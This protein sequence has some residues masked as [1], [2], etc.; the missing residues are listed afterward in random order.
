MLR[1]LINREGRMKNLSLASLIFPLFF[2]SLCAG[3]T[4]HAKTLKDISYGDAKKQKLDVYLPDNTAN[5]PIMFMVHG[6]A[7]RIGDKQNHQVVK[8]KVE[9]WR[10]RGWVFISINY[11]MLPKADPYQQARDVA[12]AL[13]HVQAHASD[14][15]A[16]SSK[17]IVMGHS[18]GA[19]LVSLVMTDPTLTD[20]RTLTSI[21]AAILL[22]SAALDINRL[23]TQDHPRLYDRAFGN[24]PNYWRKNSAIQHLHKN[25]QPILL[26][27]STRREHSCTQANAFAKKAQ[28]LGVNARQIRLD[29]S[30]GDI[31]DKLGTDSD[32]TRQVEDF[33]RSVDA[34]F[35]TYLPSTN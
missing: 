16:D 3:T 11:R 17:I 20:T 31:N 28:E 33:I 22:D 14:W 13:E 25:V 26:V 34:R 7:W 6:G 15:H 4:A 2:L 29:L 35:S 23:M 1:Q 21:Q 18:A 24:D 27:C 12:K 9:R 30:H 19:H 32:Y 10:Q 5:S 8:A